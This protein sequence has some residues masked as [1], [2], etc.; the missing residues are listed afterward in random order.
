MSALQQVSIEDA[1]FAWVQSSSGLVA[2]QVI[3]SQQTAPRPTGCYIEMTLDVQPVGRDAV[4]VEDNPAPSAGAEILHKQRGPRHGVLKL[5]CYAGSPVPESPVGA[6]NV[7]SILSDVVSSYALPTKAAMLDAGGVSVLRYEK[8]Q[9]IGGVVN[10]VIFEPRAFTTVHLGLASEIS[11]A[12]TYIQTVNA[13][14]QI[15]T[16]NQTVTV[17]LP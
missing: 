16:P 17:V 8:V 7:L 2:A 6:R 1:L 10:G 14:N 11:E 5:Q 4:T 13:T 3:W 15:V 12:G 9:R